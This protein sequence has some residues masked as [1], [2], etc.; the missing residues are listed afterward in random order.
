[1]KSRGAHN[2][3]A[4]QL[5]DM[6]FMHYHRSIERV[7]RRVSEWASYDD[8]M[9]FF[10]QHEIQIGIDECYR[11]LITCVDRFEVREAFTY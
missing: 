7:L 8:K 4:D 5:W 3:L 1:M 9:A 2:S 11:E 10:R 6:L